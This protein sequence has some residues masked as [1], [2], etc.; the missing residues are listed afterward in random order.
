M[1]RDLDP[2]DALLVLSWCCH[3][4]M[5]VALLLFVRRRQ[6]SSIKYREPV[7]MGLAAAFLSLYTLCVP[8]VLCFSGEAPYTII[9]FF[10]WH[11]LVTGV[12]TYFLTQSILVVKFHI[13]EILMDPILA[14][15]AR[16]RR[17]TYL[18][19]LLYPRFQLVVWSA[20]STLF[21]VPLVLLMDGLDDNSTVTAF[22]SNAGNSNLGRLRF[23]AGI[24]TGALILASYL[25]A[26]TTSRIVDNFGLKEA[27]ERAARIMGAGVCIY[28][29]I[30]VLIAYDVAPGLDLYHLP[31]VVGLHTAHAL[32]VVTIVLPLRASY[33]SKE[34][35]KDLK[36]RMRQTK[37]DVDQLES[38]VLYR[39]L[40]TDEGFADFLA[41]SKKELCADALLA[42]KEVQRYKEGACTIEHIFTSCLDPGA[43]LQVD[44]SPTV[45]HMYEI[46]RPMVCSTQETKHRLSI[47]FKRFHRVHPE[48]KTANLSSVAPVVDHR[49]SLITHAHISRPQSC[50]STTIC[51]DYSRKSMMPARNKFEKL[52]HPLGAE[53][54]RVIYTQVLPRFEELEATEKW[55]AFRNREKAMLSLDSIEHM[56]DGTLDHSVDIAQRGSLPC[57]ADLPRIQKML[58]RPPDDLP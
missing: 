12:V 21:N 16:V 51:D 17:T 23:Y 35:H 27:Y 34:T 28:A 8:P 11:V 30:S 42:W 10:E 57:I 24:E 54:L 38:M 26:R 37:R 20:A 3:V 6:L 32:F 2:H 33:R 47:S 1:A 36:A 39:Y 41:F 56:I 19:W 40:S 14:T 50:A 31:T 29:G 25:L 15:V 58:S 48:G 4:Y 49:T 22:D 44:I 7:P 5:P 46:Q 43:P 18:R 9:L 55:V 52:F 13:T 53:I 45:R